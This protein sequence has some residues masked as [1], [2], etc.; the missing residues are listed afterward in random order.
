MRS[1]SSTDLLVAGSTVFTSS[2]SLAQTMVAGGLESTRQVRVALSTESVREV[3][4]ER[5]TLGWS[6]ER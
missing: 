6:G 1:C 4:R 5:W 3:A 2:P